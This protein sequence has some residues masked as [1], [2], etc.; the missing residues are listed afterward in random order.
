MKIIFLDIDGVLNS[1]TD[2]IERNYYANSIN[3]D[4][5]VISPGK[6]ALLEDIVKKTG[7]KIVIS[8]MWRELYSLKE[9]YEL[10][11][12]RGFTL[13][14]TTIIGKTTSTDIT[15][16][17]NIS[18][19]RNIRIKEWLENRNDIESFVILDDEDPEN[20]DDDL[21]EHLITTIMANGLNYIE[22]DKAVKILGV[23]KE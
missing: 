19:T 5:E 23:I 2:F 17:D 13:P 7:A 14:V 16:S 10:F 22:A 15:L 9:L 3:H 21:Q 1:Y 18:R 11:V 12:N 6:L 20:F 4:N 8:S